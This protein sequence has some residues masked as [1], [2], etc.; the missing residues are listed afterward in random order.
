[1]SIG[2]LRAPAVLVAFGVLFAL[3]ARFAFRKHARRTVR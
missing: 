2:E 1:L 3:E